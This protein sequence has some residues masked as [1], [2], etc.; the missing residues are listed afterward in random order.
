MAYSGGASYQYSAKIELRV[1][2]MSETYLINK[3]FDDFDEFCVN[4]R[5][6]DLDYRQIERGAFNS[7]LLMAGTEG[8]Q[9][10]RAR[11]ERRLIQRGA[12]PSNLRAFG[13]LV[14]PGINIFW[15]GRQVSGDEIFVFPAGGELDSVSTSDFDVFVVSIA[16]ETL[17]RVCDGLSL[18]NPGELLAGKEV[19][20]CDP[21][22]L[23]YLRQFLNN[24]RRRFSAATELPDHQVMQRFAV[25]AS[26][27]FVTAI[28]K[29]RH[30]AAA[31]RPRRRDVALRKTL[32]FL[33]SGA[34][35]TVSIPTLC[36]VAHVSERTLEYAFRE[37]YGVTPKAFILAYRL[38]D[39]KK[40]LLLSDST[41]IRVCDIARRL[42]FWHLGQFAADYK[43]MFGELPSETLQRSIH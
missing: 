36:E 38:N 39:A 6:W 16:D 24:A 14:E 12:P 29:G 7:D 15:R 2:A 41:K 21:A 42:G 43:R 8:L 40:E 25:E 33:E 11:L 32:T 3:H 4:A 17:T 20:S 23:F 1:P 26:R 28:A 22:K 19:F 5:A 13:L 18:P 30:I 27:Q 10:V 31:V 35:K 34:D 37:R 9:F